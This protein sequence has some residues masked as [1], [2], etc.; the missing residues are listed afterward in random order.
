M[1][2]FPPDKHVNVGI[3]QKNI[4][5]NNIHV[6]NARN[7]IPNFTCKDM[8]DKINRFSSVLLLFFSFCDQNLL[9]KLRNLF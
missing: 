9:I 8:I 4:K 2:A 6:Y 5:T 1:I 3:N 7:L